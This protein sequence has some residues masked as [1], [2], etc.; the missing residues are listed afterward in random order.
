MFIAILPGNEFVAER[1]LKKSFRGF[2]GIQIPAHDHA[3]AGDFDPGDI[4]FFDHGMSDLTDLD[5]YAV[6]FGFDHGNVLFNGAVRSILLEQLHL[7]TAAG[8]AAA[9]CADAVLEHFNHGTA[10][11]A[12][13]DVRSFVHFLLSPLFIFPDSVFKVRYRHKFFTCLLLH[14]PDKRLKI[15]FCRNR[16][17]YAA[18][19]QKRF[20]PEWKAH[21]TQDQR[22]FRS[23][24]IFCDG[25]A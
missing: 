18:E 5:Q 1:D 19:A 21:Q 11:C 8:K 6:A 9:V 13:A 4:M 25:A 10:F 2:T 20:Y 15:Q 12:A 23:S 14:T 22:L 16:I 17:R 3:A 7:F 24:C